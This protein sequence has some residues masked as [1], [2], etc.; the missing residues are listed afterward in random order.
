MMSRADR[1]AVDAA[2]AQARAARRER[3]AAAGAKWATDC[4]LA[5]VRLVQF[6]AYALDLLDRHGKPDHSKMFPA[7]VVVWMMTMLT[8]E[9]V[10]LGHRLT[11][12]ELFIVSTLSFLNATVWRWILNRSR[13][14]VADVRTRTEVSIDER[15]RLEILQ[16]R[17]TRDGF[18]PSEPRP[19]VHPEDEP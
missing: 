6:P 10:K 17:D 18:D 16:G 7:I 15:R 11:A 1:A 9:V 2:K 4:Y 3:R 13:F 5:G 12:T 8:Y 19:A 14:S